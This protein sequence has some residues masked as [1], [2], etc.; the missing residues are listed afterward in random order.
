MYTP[1]NFVGSHSILETSRYVERSV[2]A[3]IIGSLPSGISGSRSQF[4]RRAQPSQACSG[5]GSPA[6]AVQKG[7]VGQSSQPERPEGAGQGQDDPARVRQP[8]FLPSF[9]F[10]T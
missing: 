7:S 6:R 8:Y 3:M 1:G 4:R 5:K 9:F 10:L 2:A